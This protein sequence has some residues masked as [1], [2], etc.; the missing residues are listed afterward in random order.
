VL[1]LFYI[2]D[3]I[4]VAFACESQRHIQRRISADL[5]FAQMGLR[6]AHSEVYCRLGRVL[7]NNAPQSLARPEGPTFQNR[8]TC[9]YPRLDFRINMCDQ[10]Q[11]SVLLRN[12]HIGSERALIFRSSLKPPNKIKSPH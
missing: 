5:T 7:H 11:G 1:V 8:S 2:L 4:F 9:V 3:C 10:L 12:W 6:N